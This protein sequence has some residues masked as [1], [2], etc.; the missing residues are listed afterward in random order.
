MLKENIEI[1]KVIK[2]LDKLAL[3]LRKSLIKPCDSCEGQGRPY[4]T[5]VGCVDT[6]CGFKNCYCGF[7]KKSNKIKENSK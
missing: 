4:K 1:I 5:Y 2:K 7:K 3:E 6:G